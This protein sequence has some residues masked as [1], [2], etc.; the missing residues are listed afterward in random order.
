MAII[1]S[2]RRFVTNAAVA[3]AA[4]FGALG[5]VNR[6]VA[7]DRSP[8]SRRQKYLQSA[9]TKDRSSA[10]R[11]S[12]WPRSCCTRR[13]LPTSATRLWTR[14]SP[15]QKLARDEVDWTLEF[16]PAVIEADRMAAH[17]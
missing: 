5:A 14:R 7:E 10:L 13:A 15:T 9:S 12:T 6:G 17:R 2:R 16:A 4:G 3:G 11:R 1:Q 8:P